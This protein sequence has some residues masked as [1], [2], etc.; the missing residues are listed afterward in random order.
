VAKSC[1]AWGRTVGITRRA[2]EGRRGEARCFLAGRMCRAPW[3]LLSAERLG[4]CE[5]SLGYAQP[6]LIMVIRIGRSRGV[7][8]AEAGTVAAGEP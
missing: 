6:A 2:R 1:H 4:G 5:G 8:L 7:V 3:A